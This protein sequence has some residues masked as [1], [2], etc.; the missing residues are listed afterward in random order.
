MSRHFFLS[1]AGARPSARWRVAFVEGEVA[2]LASVGRRAEPGDVIWVTTADPSW[3]AAL[4]TLQRSL[5]RCPVVALSMTPHSRE[6]A[7]ALDLGARGYC[8]A[9]AVPALLGEVAVVVSHGGLWVGREFMARA[10]RA[11]SRML[12]QAA[13]AGVADQLSEREREVAEAVL[14]GLSNKDVAGK[15]GITERT[16]KAHLASVFRKLDVRDRLQLVLRLSEV[17]APASVE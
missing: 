13:A 14:A 10:M 15:L 1:A 17:R 2:D 5:A 12:P 7:H 11:A 16:V 9:Q 4:V 6:A 3:T 8:H